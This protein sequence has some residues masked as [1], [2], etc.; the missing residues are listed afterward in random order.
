M[1]NDHQDKKLLLVQEYFVLLQSLFKLKREKT[2]LEKLF[3]LVQQTLLQAQTFLRH[4]SISSSGG[5]N[6]LLNGIRVL[7][8]TIIYHT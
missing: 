8:V 7:K 5:F 6:I 4:N 2:V 3:S 1:K